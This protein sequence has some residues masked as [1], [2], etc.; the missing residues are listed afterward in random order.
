MGSGVRISLAAPIKLL[1]NTV[2][3]ITGKLRPLRQL[4]LRTSSGP[5]G[6]KFRGLNRR[7]RTAK[8][9]PCC[10]PQHV[11]ACVSRV[12]AWDLRLCER[13]AAGNWARREGDKSRPLPSRPP[14]K[15]RLRQTRSGRDGCS[16]GLAGRSVLG[17]AGP[18]VIAMQWQ[19]CA[20][21][22]RSPTVDDRD[23]STSLGPFPHGTN[24]PGA[25]LPIR[26]FP[27]AAA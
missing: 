12:R 5:T 9:T 8:L 18:S 7:T 2:F 6:S 24:V 26:P 3:F 17:G 1:K 19:E 27:S 22:G 16:L 14:E 10:Q 13:R 20:N 21:T 4:E 23:K 15:S 11:S 25:A